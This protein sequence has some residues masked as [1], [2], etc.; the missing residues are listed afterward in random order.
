LTLGIALPRG[1]MLPEALDMLAAAG[2]PVSR[3]LADT[4]E[5]VVEVA[6]WRLLLARPRDVGLY[7]EHGVADLGVA[8]KDTLLEHPRQAIE[9]LDLGFGRC[10]LVLAAPCGATG[11]TRPPACDLRALRRVATKY[12]RLTGTFLQ[13]QGSPAQVIHVH[14]AVELAASIGLAD[15][16]VDL[17]QTGQTLRANGLAEV[18]TI[19]VSSARLI[20]NPAAFRVGPPSLQS[21]IDRLR[22]IIIGERAG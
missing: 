11:A 10:R 16:V 19:T 7:V 3:E 13:A 14:G 21:T 9:L 1:R 5:L 6:G 4:R 15:A 20:A 8:G 2:L 22:A 12:P 18:A 17:T